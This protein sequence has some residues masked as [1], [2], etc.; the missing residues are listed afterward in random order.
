MNWIRISLTILAAGSVTSVTD[1]LFMGDWLYK[2]YNNS[3]EIWRY[4]HGEGET[5]AIAWA[6]PLPFLTCA[7]FTFLCVGLNLHSYAATA[8]LALAIWLIG[9]LPLL[10]VTGLFIKLHAAITVSY[11]IGWLIKLLAAAG[12]VAMILR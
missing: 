1:W 9:P 5:R 6:A 7:V 10:I 3:P 11:S 12:A 4:P 2:R 8:K